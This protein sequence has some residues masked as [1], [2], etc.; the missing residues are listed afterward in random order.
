ML[1]ISGL[2]I[3]LLGFMQGFSKT[4]YVSNSGNDTYP[5]TAQYPKETIQN[6]ADM[7]MPGD[8][9][10]VMEGVYRERVA[11]PRGGVE[12][13]EIV[14]QGE[15]GKKVIIKGS[16]EWS[17]EWKNEYAN[18]YYATPNDSMFNDDVYIDNKNPFLVPV[19]STPYGLD[20][21]PE[22][23]RGYGGDPDLV[24]SIGQ[25][26]V[27][28]ELYTQ[29]GYLRQLKSTLKSW[30]VDMSTGRIYIRFP[31]N[32]PSAHKV[33]ISTR[34]RIFASHLRQLGYI[35]VEGFIMEH[36]G[37]Q[38]PT[39]FWQKDSPEWQQAGA[40][41]TR[42]GHHWTIKNNVIH[43]VHGVGI[44]F[45]NEGNKDVD[46]ET[47][48]NGKAIGAGHH[49]IDSN[50]ITDNGSG[51]TA[52]YYP[53]HITFTNNVVE[54]NNN[55][56]F[57]G[58]KRWESA[59][60]KIHDPDH[61]IIANNLIRNNYA[62]W[63]L[64]LDQGSGDETRVHGNIIIGHEK[65]FDVEIGDAY[66]DK[67]IFDN[68]ILINNERAIVSRESGGI[69][70]LNNLILGSYE[71]G[72]ENTV[73]INRSGTWVS[74]A[75]H[76]FNNIFIDNLKHIAVEA[77]D[78]SKTGDR[79]FDFNIYKETDDHNKWVI[80]HGTEVSNFSVW[81]D[82]WKDYNENLNY[83]KNSIA[84]DGIAYMFNEITF[85]LCIEIGFDLDLIKGYSH[86]ALDKDF[87]G[88]TISELNRIIPGPFQ[89][90]KRGHN[91]F[92]IWQDR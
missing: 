36:C 87:T 88:Q 68:N 39:N 46:L 21:R 29:R 49:F 20:G 32:D 81:K 80:Y 15:P 56:K 72:L 6:A 89:H 45:G 4:I 33:E 57:D 92:K 7:A 53:D 42:S 14:Y 76:H 83:D 34:R 82:A 78:Y 28:G 69:T 37:N 1:L 31:D 65:G 8:T 77:P 40:L 70:T 58:P 48:D 55:L 43:F 27:D 25:V 24:F 79:Q 13:K 52:A 22:F 3:S 11:P 75:H 73:N 9:I 74:S 50:H 26:F 19:S 12:G 5:G 30:Y 64:W 16:N 71:Y 63:G 41:G 91:C 85:E 10:Y 17:P 59:G 67:L 2:I 86:Q 44:D 47:G 23:E 60:V 90:L 66:V 84:I 61:S 62:G 35:V 51:G 18:I 38:Y 54:R